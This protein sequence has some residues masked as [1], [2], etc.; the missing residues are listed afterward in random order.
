[1]KNGKENGWI[2]LE[3]WGWASISVNLILSSLNLVIAYASGSLAVLAELVHNLVDLVASI[4]VLV[5]L[6][7][8]KRKSRGFPYGLYKIENMVAAVIALLIFLACYEIVQEALL[9]KG[10]DTVVTPW[11][12]GG[13]GLSLLIPL[14]FSF[15][16]MRAG[17][18]ANSPSLVA[19][20]KEY[21][22]HGLTSGVVLVSLIAHT[23]H[24]PVDKI[25]AFVVV[26]VVARTG[27]KLLSDS[28][29]VLLDASLDAGTLMQAREIIEREPTVAEI[30]SLMGRNAGRYQ[31]LEAEVEVKVRELERADLVARR[32][33][34]ALGKEIPHVERAIVDIKPVKSESLRLALPVEEHENLL[35]QHFGTASTF[36][37]VEKRRADGDVIG[38]SV[39]TNP[40]ARDPKGRGI[41]VAHW[42]I[43]QKVDAVL[44]LDDIRNKGPGHALGDAG[45]DVIVTQVTTVEEAI[46]EGWASLR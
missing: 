15:F 38:R 30:H 29:R 36:I 11:I 10:K 18:A 46:E 19:D 27:W 14:A 16:E 6:K 1:M 24:L 44:T 20:A 12:I 39:I 31:F 2:S 7:L 21:R 33:E 41:K 43:G 34:R 13:I 32:L 35:D 4:A 28:M 25:A 3:K 45:I 40:F 42:L 9:S 17:R 22:S 23:V 26:V 37:V 5:G 8:S